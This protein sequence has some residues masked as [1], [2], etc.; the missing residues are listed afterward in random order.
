[1]GAQHLPVGRKLHPGFQAH[2]LVVVVARVCVGGGRAVEPLVWVAGRG[3]FCF[4]APSTRSCAVV[5]GSPRVRA[6]RGNGLGRAQRP[7]LPGFP[8]A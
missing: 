2:V 3:A 7:Q 4:A 1:M 8:R 6:L 5:A